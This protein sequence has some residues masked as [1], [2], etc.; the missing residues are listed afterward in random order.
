MRKG[1]IELSDKQYVAK[2]TELGREMYTFT[3]KTGY[4]E[5]KKQV[6][7]AREMKGKTK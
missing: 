2:P 4:V 6:E 3:M 5:W 7:E 1:A